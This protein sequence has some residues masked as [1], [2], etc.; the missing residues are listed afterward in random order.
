MAF[1]R[2]GHDVVG[3]EFATLRLGETFTNGGKRRG[4]DR[5]SRSVGVGHR[6]NRE[7]DRILIVFGQLPH[8]RDGLIEQLCHAGLYTMKA[9]EKKPASI[10]GSAP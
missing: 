6:K 5:D 3:N 8:C 2:F 10:V 7:G 4:I 1:I 9:S